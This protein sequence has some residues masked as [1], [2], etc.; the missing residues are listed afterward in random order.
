MLSAS[1]VELK[2]FI[3]SDKVKPLGISSKERS[4]YLPDVPTI[5]ETL[6]TPYV[7]TYNGLLGPKDT[8]A[9][10]IEMLAI[11][12]V[13]A[14]KTPEFMDKL[15]KIGVEPAGTTPQEMAAEIAADTERWKSVANDI[16]PPKSQ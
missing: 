15:A 14:E 1:P 9:E 4:R 6:P 7:A 8:P 2:P 3:G 12:I 5:S 10:I 11:E 13:A 16:A